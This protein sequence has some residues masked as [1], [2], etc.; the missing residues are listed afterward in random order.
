M[1]NFLIGSAL[2]ALVVLCIALPFVGPWPLRVRFLATAPL[3]DPWLGLAVAPRFQMRMVTLEA[4][5]ARDGHVELTVDE[6]ARGRDAQPAVFAREGCSPALVAQLEGWSAV[7]TSLLLAIEEDGHVH[8]YGPRAS[9]T[10]LVPTG[11]A[12]R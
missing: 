3:V 1:S 11:S 2:G 12:V 7:H 5:E 4:V 6:P 10:D 9:V 8:L